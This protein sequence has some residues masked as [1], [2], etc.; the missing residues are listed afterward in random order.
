M[1]ISKVKKFGVGWCIPLKQKLMQGPCGPWPNI[2]RVKFTI[3]NWTEFE[4]E[5]SRLGVREK[6]LW[7]GTLSCAL[8][9]WE[10]SFMTKNGL[11][12]NMVHK[13][14]F[15]SSLFLQVLLF[16]FPWKLTYTKYT[17]LSCTA[18]MCSGITVEV[19]LKNCNF[20]KLQF[21]TVDL[22]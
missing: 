10:G 21:F 6:E 13:Y 9:V 4:I 5:Q 17:F 3:S 12:T 20:E 2:N 15:Y 1:L 11:K 18:N 19:H 7:G 22:C 16:S 8:V 14:N